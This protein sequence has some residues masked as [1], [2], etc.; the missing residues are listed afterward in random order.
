M[1]PDFVAHP[2]FTRSL[3]LFTSFA[4]FFFNLFYFILFTS[5]KILQKVFDECQWAVSQH[6]E[7][8]WQMIYCIE[9]IKLIKLH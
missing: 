3:F 8:S 1:C 2:D 6:P 9:Y 5:A 7:L 4:V